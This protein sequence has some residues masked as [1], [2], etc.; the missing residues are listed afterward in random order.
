VIDTPMAP[1][2]KRSGDGAAGLIVFQ[3]DGQ[4]E[5]IFATGG[6][7]NPTKADLEAMDPQD[8]WDTWL[9]PALETFLVEHDSW[10]TSIPDPVLVDTRQ[11]AGRES[12]PREHHSGHGTS[13]RGPPEDD[14]HHQPAGRQSQRSGRVA[15]PRLIAIGE[16]S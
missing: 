2:A 15:A 5:I 13:R 14:P 7:D 12:R 16:G 8:A 1:D 9:R 3:D 10:L 11:P 4:F 6:P